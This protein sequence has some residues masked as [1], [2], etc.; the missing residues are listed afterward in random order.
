MQFFYSKPSFL[1]TFI[2]PLLLAIIQFMIQGIT[3][4]PNLGTYLQIFS[5]LMLTSFYTSIHCC[6]NPLNSTYSYKAAVFLSFWSLSVMP[7]SSLY[8]SHPHFATFCFHHIPFTA[9]AQLSENIQ[10]RVSFLNGKIYS[11]EVFS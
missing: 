5:T 4:L 2:T 9:E 7:S 1:S 8:H 11:L 10:L 3:H 6:L